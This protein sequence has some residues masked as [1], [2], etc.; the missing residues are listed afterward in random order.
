VGFIEDLPA[1][2]L[3]AFAATL[4]ELEDADLLIHLVD[5]SIPDFEERMGI[6]EAVL[7]SLNLSQTPVLVVFNKIDRTSRESVRFVEQ[8]YDAAAISCVT[9]EGIEALADRLEGAL[10]GLQGESKG[11]PEGLTLVLQRKGK[12]PSPRGRYP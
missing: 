4:E 7:I 1:V 3:R 5:I 12:A 10:T 8:R 11:L 2:L 9:G 6:V